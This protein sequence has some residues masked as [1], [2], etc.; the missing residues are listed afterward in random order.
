M[1][2]K[3]WEFF[4]MIKIKVSYQDKEELEH[5]INL[6]G[7]QNIKQFKL[8]KN[9]QGVYKKA[10]VVIKDRIATPNE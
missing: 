8:S 7:Q 4:L 9:N 2:W 3:N 1:Y 5:I 6:I 10:Y